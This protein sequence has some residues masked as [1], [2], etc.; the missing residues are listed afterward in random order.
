LAQLWAAAGNQQ[1]AAMVEQALLAVEQPQ[2]FMAQAAVDVQ[3][4]V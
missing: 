2:H 3:P 4:P 1:A